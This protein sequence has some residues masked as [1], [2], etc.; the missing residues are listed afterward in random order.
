VEL[1]YINT[2]HPDFI[3][4]KQAVAQLNRKFNQAPDTKSNVEAVHVRLDFLLPVE[5]LLWSTMYAG[6]SVI[7][8][9]AY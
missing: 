4:G 2:S 8:L 1:A 3:G 5:L 7:V 9:Y 6:C